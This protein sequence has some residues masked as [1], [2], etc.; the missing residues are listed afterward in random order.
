[1]D[2]SRSRI[3]KLLHHPRQ[4]SKSFLYTEAS[5]GSKEVPLSEGRSISFVIGLRLVSLA[6][7]TL[8]S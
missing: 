5:A 7:L 8:T 2:I 1:M 3:N 6:T 4:M